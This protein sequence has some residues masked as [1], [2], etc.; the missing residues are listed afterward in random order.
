MRQQLRLRVLLPLA[1]LGL[2][3]AGFGA[4]AFGQAPEPASEPLPPTTTEAAPA[5]PKAAGAVGRKAW[6]A[7]MNAL[8]AT[9]VSELEGMALREHPTPKELESLL[10]AL[11]KTSA[12]FD[13][14][15]AR[16]GWPRGE[17]AAVVALRAASVRETALG[18]S[19]LKA[20]R[21]HDFERFLRVVDRNS[22]G[23]GWKAEMRR[24]GARKCA[25]EIELGDATRSAE[26]AKGGHAKMPPAVALEWA[27]Y[28]K[29]SAV[30]LFYT[31]TSGLDGTTVLE[32]RS[33][34]L[35]TGAA[36]LPVNVKA[37]GQV[38]ELAERYDVLEAPAILVFVRGPAPKLA[39]RFDRFA[40]RQTVA[41]AVENALR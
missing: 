37:N 39:A 30:V 38:S 31:P 9:A 34:A 40:D 19:A 1:V 27:L 17:K 6:A 16:V 2:L 35:D 12:T 8:C 13:K 20:F 4:Y 25:R 33:A 7:E 24:L 18:R 5:K 10:K 41:Q 11:V 3:G 15:F 21:A 26:R 23:D 22:A 29:R 14:A 32:T 28:F 36:F